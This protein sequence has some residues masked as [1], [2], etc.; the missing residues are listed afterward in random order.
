MA[1]PRRDPYSVVVVQGI[2][3]ADQ[4]ERWAIVRNPRWGAGGNLDLYP[5]AL[6]S[7]WRLTDQAA[8]AEASRPQLSAPASP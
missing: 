2:A 7:P 6:R 4:P 1:G 8:A 5:R 3:I